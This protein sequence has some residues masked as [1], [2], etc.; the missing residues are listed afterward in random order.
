MFRNNARGSPICR[1][2]SASVILLDINKI[3]N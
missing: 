1:A 2:F 3:N